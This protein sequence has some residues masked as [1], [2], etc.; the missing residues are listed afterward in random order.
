[1]VRP[2]TTDPDTV[3][4]PEKYYIVLI[5]SHYTL[6]G[7][8]GGPDT[9]HDQAIWTRPMRAGSCS[10]SNVKRTTAREVMM[11]IASFDENVDSP[12]IDRLELY[13]LPENP[14]YWMQR[15]LGGR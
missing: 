12:R 10:A 2:I 3:L 6:P 13:E 1:M 8:N 5:R 4:D 11:F 15:H 7:S 9:R 14:L